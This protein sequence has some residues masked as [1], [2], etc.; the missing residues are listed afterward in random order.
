[1]RTISNRDGI[2][3]GRKAGAEILKKIKGAR[4]SVKIVSPYLSASFVQELIKL[5]KE[6]RE[7]TLITASQG[8]ARE[9]SSLEEEGRSEHEQSES[10]RGGRNPVRL[11]QCRKA[12]AGR[13]VSLSR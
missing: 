6:G 4:K 12:E 9:S 8:F 10:R 2:Y 1:M 11:L 3:I 7:I 13:R 5:R